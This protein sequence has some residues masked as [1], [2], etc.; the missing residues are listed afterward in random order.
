MTIP[1]P[2]LALNAI[3]DAGVNELVK[4]PRKK[5]MFEGAT[6]SGLSLLVLTPS[7]KR[8]AGGNGWVDFT[9]IQIELCEQYDSAIVAFCIADGDTHFVDMAQLLPCLT[10]SCQMENEREGKHWKL[11]IWD[12][13]ISV[14]NGGESIPT[15]KNSIAEIQNALK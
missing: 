11:D 3:R 1:Q 9:D 7:S 2:E 15:Q 13:R 12:D 10:D 14:R 4:L 6:P 8:Y 5:I